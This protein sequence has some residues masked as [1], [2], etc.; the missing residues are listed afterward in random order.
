MPISILIIIILV[1]SAIL[2][3]Y[4]HGWVAYKLGDNTA[5]NEGRLTLN[6]IAHID[7]FGTIILPALLILTKTGII[8][9]W[10]KPVPYNPYNLI[11]QKYGD[12]KVAI[13]G[14]ISNFALATFFGLIARLLPLTDQ[15]KYTLVNNFFLKDYDRLI[16]TMNDSML[17]SVFVMSIIFCF[18][19][20]LLMIFNLI[21]IP[22]LDGSKVLTTYLPTNAKIFMHRIEPYGIFII[23]LFLYA[24]ILNFI[25]PLIITIFS[26]LTGL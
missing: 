2:H 4:A 5:K 10:A 11:D 18:I 19:N 15:I 24:G 7:L 23:I 13:G 8:I 20:L 6:P 1:I 9:G 14:P 16:N 12:L 22:P 21:P 25:W 26:F 17:S 3:E